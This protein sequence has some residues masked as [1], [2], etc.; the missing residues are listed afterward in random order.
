MDGKFKLRDV[1]N[2]NWAKEEIAKR[3]VDFN[4]PKE[5]IKRCVGIFLEEELMGFLI[6]A[7]F[8]GI[9]SFHGYKF[10]EWHLDDQ[11]RIARKYIADEKLEFSGFRERG[12]GKF[13]E[14]LGFKEFCMINEF[15]LARKI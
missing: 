1:S 15:H 10:C 13:L 11:M 5:Y 12:A 9:K 4:F 3:V 14:R 8:G 7:E 2:W 6:T